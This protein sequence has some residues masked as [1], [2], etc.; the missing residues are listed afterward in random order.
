M[1]VGCCGNRHVI[2]N[3]NNITK[4]IKNK[5][6]IKLNGFTIIHITHIA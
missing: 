4:T 5:R 6:N 1:T 2:L 3:R